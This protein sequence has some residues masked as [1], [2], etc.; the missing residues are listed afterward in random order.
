M[1]NAQIAELWGA[2]HTECRVVGWLRTEFMVGGV[3]GSTL[4]VSLPLG[5][6]VPWREAESSALSTD[7]KLQGE[8]CST[9]TS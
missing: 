2:L 5:H 7:R 6:R 4:L 9:A 1:S 8:M 3:Q